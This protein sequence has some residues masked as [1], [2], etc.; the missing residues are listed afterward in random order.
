MTAVTKE[1]AVALVTAQICT[2]AIGLHP[3]DEI[4]IVGE[5]TIEKSWGWVFFYTS[6]K[7]RETKEVRY[8]LA[9][10]A[11]I[12]VERSSGR[13]IPTGTAKHQQL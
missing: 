13:L 9:G 12:I 4:I 6:R 5:A 3:D 8:A 10:N 11:P 1:Q 2:R 7:Y